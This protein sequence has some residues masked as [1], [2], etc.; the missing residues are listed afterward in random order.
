MF[1]EDMAEALDYISTSLKNPAAAERL[2]DLTEKAILVPICILV[3]C[4]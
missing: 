4:Q 2:L 3:A 1:E